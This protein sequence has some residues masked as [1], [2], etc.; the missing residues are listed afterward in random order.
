MFPIHHYPQRNRRMIIPFDAPLERSRRTGSRSL[1]RAIAPQF[2][3][4]EM[5]GSTLHRSVH[6]SSD[7]IFLYLSLFRFARNDG[8]GQYCITNSNF[9]TTTPAINLYS[10][11]SKKLI[12]TKLFEKRGFCPDGLSLGE[13]RDDAHYSFNP[14][15]L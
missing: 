7:L 11:L 6:Y 8:E 2:T 9:I 4:S 15:P 5:K 13:G 14:C 3:Q 1:L 10:L 12:F